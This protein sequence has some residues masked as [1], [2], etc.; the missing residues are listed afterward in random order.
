MVDKWICL[1]VS[2]SF[3]HG[4]KSAVAT[5]LRRIFG[6]DLKEIRIVCDDVMWQSGEY[7]C[8]ILCSNY[9]N[10]IS[11]LKEDALFFRVIPSF[12]K[13]NYL[14]QEEVEG[15]TVSVE[16][17]GV[18][19]ELSKGDVV[20][21]KE[22]YLKNLYGLVIER[23]KGKNKKFRI[24]FHFYLKKFV[25]SVPATSLQFMDNIFR[26]RKFPITREDL[27]SGKIPK[28]TIDKAIWEVIKKF[29]NKHKIYRKAHRKRLKAK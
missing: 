28:K 22:G 12:D 3:H 14:M 7:Y 6:T 18:P 29:A 20:F 2:T 19:T 27:L 10:H 23:D 5:E 13:P 25:A 8:F 26:H 15:F 24:S 9:G 16:R 11:A 17:A 1:T 21:V 4:D